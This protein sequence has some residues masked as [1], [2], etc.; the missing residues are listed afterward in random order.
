MFKDRLVGMLTPVWQFRVLSTYSIFPC[1]RK[2]RPLAPRGSAAKPQ[3]ITVRPAEPHG[4]A[5]AHE[6]PHCEPGPQ[7]QEPS[8]EETLLCIESAGSSSRHCSRMFGMLVGHRQAKRRP[9]QALGTEYQSVF[10]PCFSCVPECL[11]HRKLRCH[12]S[13]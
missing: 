4:V 6:L 10:T 8:G 3:H 5:F 9:S 7:V 1:G 11:A 2:P 12:S 13:P